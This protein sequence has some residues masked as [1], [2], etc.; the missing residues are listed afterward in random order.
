MEIIQKLSGIN[1]IA[2]KVKLY[3]SQHQIYELVE[4]DMVSRI[5]R[6]GKNTNVKISAPIFLRDI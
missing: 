6:Q 4:I 3:Y 2:S 5:F 1:L